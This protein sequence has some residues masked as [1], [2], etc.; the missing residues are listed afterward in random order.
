MENIALLEITTATSIIGLMLLVYIRITKN[1]MKK[2]VLRK[3]GL[4]KE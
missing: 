2:F 3:G 4:E 1:K